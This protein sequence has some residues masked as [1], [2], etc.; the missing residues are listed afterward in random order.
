M[1]IPINEMTARQLAA[2]A[3]VE[4]QAAAEFSWTAG[5]HAG[6]AQT[7]DTAANWLQ[8][9]EREIERQGKLIEQLSRKLSEWEMDDYINNGQN[10]RRDIIESRLSG[11]DAYREVSE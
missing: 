8:E 11:F 1:Y 3:K 10:G 6:R 2:D 4:E 9:A 5:F 7:W